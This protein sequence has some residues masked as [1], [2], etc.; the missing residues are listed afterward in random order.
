MNGSSHENFISLPANSW[1]YL[2][3]YFAYT[4]NWLP[5]IDKGEIYKLT[6]SY[7]VPR[8]VIS[9]PSTG[10]GIHAALWAILALSSRQDSAQN[11]S[12]EWPSERLYKT[13]RKLI[14]LEGQLFE[15]GHV[16][17]LLLLSLIKCGEGL[18]DDAWLLIGQAVR[19]SLLI[20]LNDPSCLFNESQRAFCLNGRQLHVFLSCFILDTI[21]SATLG[22]PCQLRT[23][24]IRDVGRLKENGEE[25]W[26]P[27]TPIPGF[28][29]QN[30]PKSSGKRLLRTESTFNQLLDL[31]SI[32][33][34]FI[35]R[36]SD[37]NRSLSS[38]QYS[39]LLG[40]LQN[41]SDKL[42]PQC[43]LPLHSEGILKD[44]CPPPQVLTLH[45]L[46]ASTLAILRKEANIGDPCDISLQTFY[47]TPC[48][49]L[50]AHIL[51]LLKYYL[52]VHGMVAIPPVLDISITSALSYAAIPNLHLGLDNHVLG[53]L[54]EV[55]SH[56]RGV[57]TENKRPLS[58]VP[59]VTSH[60]DKPMS[61]HELE[62]ADA[63]NQQ[64]LQLS[65]DVSN[66]SSINDSQLPGMDKSGNMI[67]E[68]S[69]NGCSEYEALLR[70]SLSS[71]HGTPSFTKN[72][73]AL[74][75]GVKIFNSQQD[76]SRKDAMAESIG[77]FYDGSD[78]FDGLGL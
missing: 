73:A 27:W 28:S 3:I 21:I 49:T 8:S 1:V 76:L 68:L 29:G 9:E 56:Q 12:A 18:W 58:Q 11:K 32:L 78:T 46:F 55:L 42:P 45:L 69:H 64:Q 63:L 71:V 13:A 67:A 72:K 22:K 47:E 59:L 40:Q 25:E 2:D 74:N 44:N 17:A 4:H 60:L 16:Q 26:T 33:N 61:T 34:R 62:F 6:H 23:D 50:P 51:N 14:P 65:D 57:F 66:W 24:A 48:S 38:A 77:W 36:R 52:E 43:R 19:L 15:L 35:N 31:V 30:C 20:G 53:D 39:F 75:M 41:W 54:E 37:S 10:S 7:P 5:I 70:Q